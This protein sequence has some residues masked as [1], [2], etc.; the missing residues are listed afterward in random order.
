MA[1]HTTAKGT[2]ITGEARIKMAA[3]LKKKY[4][5]GASIRAPW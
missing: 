2:R 3:D 4:E 1:S 5:K